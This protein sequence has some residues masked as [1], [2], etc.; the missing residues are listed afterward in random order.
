MKEIKVYVHRNRIADV[1]AA[2][3]QSGLVDR[4]SSPGVRNINA[5]Q[6]QSLL[7][8]VDRAEQRYSVELGEAVIDEVRLE[9]LCE[10]S[11]VAALVTL[12]DR[13]A[14]TGQAIAGWICVHDVVMA[15]PFGG[16]HI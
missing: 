16:P 1:I 7:K 2:I 11:Q 3:N 14:R 10:D 9:L 13:T 5:T 6:V 12:I 8:P 15:A 4:R